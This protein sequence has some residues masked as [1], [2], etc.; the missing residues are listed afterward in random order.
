MAQQD[1]ISI[2]CPTVDDQLVVFNPKYHQKKKKNPNPKQQ[3]LLKYPASLSWHYQ[4]LGFTVFL[5][6]NEEIGLF[7][8]F[9]FDN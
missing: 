1:I 3:I 5:L 9:A 8:A 4:D 6:M 7:C 2:P